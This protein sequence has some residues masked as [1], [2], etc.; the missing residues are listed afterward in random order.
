MPAAPELAFAFEARADLAAPLEIG[1][2]PSGERRIIPITG[3]DFEGP[4]IK[5]RVLPGGADWQTIREDGFTDVHARY[6]LETDGGAL[7][8]VVS[9]GMRHGP[10]G[11]MRRLRAGESVDPSEYY[12]RT[13]VTFECAAPELAWLTRAIFIATGERYANRAVI[14]YWRLL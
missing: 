3:G 1:P 12:F 2:T 14:R 8:G 9:R 6:T 5:G 10:A 11:V 13:T 4:G 7:I